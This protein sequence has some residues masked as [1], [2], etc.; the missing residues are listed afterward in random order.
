MWLGKDEKQKSSILTIYIVDILHDIIPLNESA[1]HHF[2]RCKLMIRK[3]S[4]L[5]EP[6]P[7]GEMALRIRGKRV[8]A[9]REGVVLKG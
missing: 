8:L 1:H 5:I 2:D 7:R 4:S 9:L 3:V 6:L